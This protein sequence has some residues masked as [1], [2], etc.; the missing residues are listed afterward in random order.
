M[1]PTGEWVTQNWGCGGNMTTEFYADQYRRYATYCRNYGENRLLKVAGGASG[2]NY[3]WTETLLKK[4]Q[5]HM[6][7]GISLHHY[8]TDRGNKGSV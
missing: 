7:W 2:D 6:M 4:I 5:H 3:E 8:M 1:S